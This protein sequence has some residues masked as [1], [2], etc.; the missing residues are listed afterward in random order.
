MD[1]VK[2]QGDK[3]PAF[4]RNRKALLLC[5]ADTFSQDRGKLMK[6]KTKKN[7][8]V[9]DVIYDLMGAFLQA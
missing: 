3:T 8:V 1:Y 6:E 4:L 9:K 5:K 2:K 7:E